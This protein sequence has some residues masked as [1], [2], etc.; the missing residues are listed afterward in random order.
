VNRRA[1]RARTTTGP[2]ATLHAIARNVSTRYLAIG[3]EAALGLVLLPFNLHA[4]GRT[5]YGLWMLAASLTGYISVLDLGYAGAL[6]KFVAHYR[7]RRDPRAINEI[8]STLFFLFAAVGL[9][10]LAAAALVAASVGALF[11]LPPGQAAIAGSVLLILGVQVGCAFPFSVFGAVVNGFQRYDLNNV[12]GAVT[13]VA[14]ALVNLVIVWA[15]FGVVP[16]VAATTAIRVGALVVYRRNAYRVFPDLRIDHRLIRVARLREVTGFSA[17]VAVLDWSARL[18]YSLGAVVIG[19]VLGPLFVAAWTVSQR[20]A[21]AIQRLTNQLND[22]L[23]PVVVDSDASD[24]ADRLRL[25]LVQGTRLSLAT[26]LPVALSVGVLADPLLAAWVGPDA[27][28][29]TVTRLLAAA[30]IVRVGSATSM[31]VLKGAGWH[32]LLAAANVTTALANLS[33]ALALAPRFGLPG[34]ALAMLVP[35]SLTGCLVVLPSACRRAGLGL[36]EALRVAVWPAAWPALVAVAWLTAAHGWV[37]PSLAAVALHSAVAGLL[38]LALFVRWG[39]PRDERRLYLSKAAG[40][41]A[42]VRNM[43]AAI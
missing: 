9:L 2:G 30:A 43:E 7:A 18:N 13:S 28:S 23:F 17:F 8:L 32:R 5:T 41:I 42:R 12:A 33:I 4:L 35:V 22:V 20:L 31:T 25:I 10:V 29:A 3:V 11:D 15:G 38:Y 26:V 37:A 21:E 34:V 1:D 14:A 40:L 19:A 39:L 6:T 24:R 36:G 27:A 16:L